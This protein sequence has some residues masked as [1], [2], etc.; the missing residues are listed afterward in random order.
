MFGY[1]LL[2]NAELDRR[3]AD[4]R[5]DASHMAQ[6]RLLNALGFKEWCHQSP[7]PETRII[8]AEFDSSELIYT[9]RE[10]T[11][12]MSNSIGSFWKLASPEISPSKAI[13]R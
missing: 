3:I 8:L 1:R 7:P 4:Q 11:N 13:R 2:K 6:R 9:E 12:P 10:R 5:S